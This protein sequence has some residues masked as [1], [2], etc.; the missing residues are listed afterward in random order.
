MKRVAALAAGLALCGPAGAQDEALRGA[1]ERVLPRVV[2]WRRAI[3]AAPELGEREHRTAAL[4]A[5]ELAALG[6]EVQT[7]VGG[8]GVVA[9]LRGAAPE[10]IVC[11]RADMDALP[12]E[13]RTGL[14]FASA[15]RD[16]WDGALVGV[17]HACGHDLHVAI[18]LGAASVLA[19]PAVRAA[20]PGSVLFVFQP[21]EEGLPDDLPHGAQRMLAE[22][23]FEEHRPRA[24]FGLHVDPLLAVGQVGLIP[25][26]ALA[27]VDRFRVVVHGKQAHGAHPQEGVDPIVAA[28]SLVLALQTIASRNVDPQDAVVVT[29]GKLAAGN[30]FNVIPESAELLGT[31][32]THDE[33]VQALVHERLRALATSV[34]AG[35]G[36]RAEVEIRTITPVTR[37]DPALAER[38]RPSLAAVV[39]AENVVAER[40]HMGGEDFAFFAREVPGLYLFLGTSDFS[41]GAPAM[42]HTP[43]YAPEEGALEVGLACAVRVLQDALAQR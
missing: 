8:T 3:H 21:A 27:A 4:V 20:L 2:A 18:A 15:A 34:C 16:T 23:A 37:N 35:F 12:I 10:P 29:V 28:S 14:P 24:A 33:R 40:P 17:M 19:D 43:A 9:L 26:G 32:R 38:M 41:K 13:E 1:L 11:W 5:R 31:I 39:G 6:L 30:R 7:G 25:G 42:I 36:A 22:G